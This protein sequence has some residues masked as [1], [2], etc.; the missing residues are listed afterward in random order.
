MSAD[1]EARAKARD[2]FPVLRH[3]AFLNAGTFGPLAEATADA[4]AAAARA[5][6]EGGRGGAPYYERLKEARG[7][8]RSGIAG[9]VGV[10]ASRV[11][12]TYSTTSGCK[13]VLAGLELASEDEVVTTDEEHFG[14]LGP[15][16]ASG[17]RV[18]VV[19]TRGKG[20][21]E[22]L[23]AILGAVSARTRLVAMSHVSWITGNLLPVA[24]VKEESG[25]PMLVDGAQSAGAIPVD[26]TGFDFYTIS[27]QKW[28]CG[29]DAAGALYVADPQALRV[30]LPSYWGRSAH[31]VDGAFEPVEG[32][33]RFDPGT[34]PLPSLAGLAAA[35]A[36]APA[37]R[38]EAARE[39]AARC[40]DL[41]AER[42]EVVTAP[43]QATLVTFR[44]DGDAAEVVE[45][46]RE[47]GVIVRDLPGTEW[48]RVSCGYWTS[49]EDLE[50]LL[51]GL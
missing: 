46:L 4:V 25:L 19:P 2:A 24:E 47:N 15:L 39:M 31:E 35:L 8:V 20:H 13:I 6:L 42:L 10:D 12:L 11:A 44:P 28:L 32:A 9:L 38:F 7:R 33:G 17:A 48:V 29:P 45:R 49:E 27:G 37:W 14:L 5:E 34:I 43:G 3:T 23:A 30:G 41:L 1:P 16:H 21:D 22:A 18:R 40:R 50:R 36:A 26:A 51:A